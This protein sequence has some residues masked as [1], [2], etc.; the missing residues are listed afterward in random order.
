LFKS[1]K[2]KSF[3]SVISIVSFK[4]IQNN[5]NLECWNNNTVE[6]KI[7]KKII[8]FKTQIPL[9]QTNKNQNTDYNSTKNINKPK[10]NITSHKKQNIFYLNKIFK[11]NQQ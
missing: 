2:N 9:S 10:N 7:S 6:N 4:L 3:P 11:I 8:N 1:F 5:I